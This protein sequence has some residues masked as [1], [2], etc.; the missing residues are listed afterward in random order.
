V[1]GTPFSLGDN[2]IGDAMM[3]GVQAA[4]EYQPSETE[5][6][7]AQLSAKKAEFAEERKQSVDQWSA[8]AVADWMS[9][10]TKL[11]MDV[12]KIIEMDLT[13]EDLMDVT[14]EMLDEEFDVHSKLMQTKII[15]AMK[16]LVAGDGG[17]FL[18]KAFATLTRKKGKKI[19]SEK[20]EEVVFW[21]DGGGGGGAADD[22]GGDD[23]EGETSLSAEDIALERE[24]MFIDAVE[25]AQKI[26][27]PDLIA[28]R[29]G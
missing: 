7:E 22:D 5:I 8:E 6:K 4:L 25:N 19:A 17:G 21:D 9:E 26:V 14:L 12:S 24:L 23:K 13:G 1:F 10:Q 15:K 16:K 27:Q 28:Y 11:V 18:K 2:Q 29:H 3:E 20:E